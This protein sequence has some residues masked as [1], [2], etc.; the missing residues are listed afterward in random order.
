M[1]GALLGL[2]L[3]W[4]RF[5]RR[6]VL[7]LTAG[8]SLTV[9]PWQIARTISDHPLA[10]DRVSLVSERLGFAF[11][12]LAL[13]QPVEDALFFVTLMTILFW[14][15]GLYSGYVFMRY[16]GILSAV[17]PVTIPVLV[18]QYYD[19]GSQAR[20]WLTGFYFFLCLLL[21]G[22]LNYVQNKERW[23]KQ[24]VFLIPEIG[25]DLNSTTLAAVTVVMV[26]AWSMPS[27]RA[28]WK[29]AI[30]WWRKT[31]DSFENT[32]ERLGDALAAVQGAPPGGNNVLYGST[33]PLGQR[34]YQ[35]DQV[36]LVVQPQPLE[37]PP[38]RLYWRM[39][40]YDTYNNAAWSHSNDIVD[41]YLPGTAD[42]RTPDTATRFPGEFIFTN[43]ADGQ[44][45]I[46]T[47]PQPVWVSRDALISYTRLPDNL[48]DVDRLRADPPLRRDEA[49][50]ARSALVAP[51]VADL[52]QAGT[53][54][55]KWVTD[56]YLQLPANL[57]QSIRHLG[58]ELTRGLETP[59]DKAAAITRYLR[60]EITYSDEIPA[61][62]SG[63]DRLEWF[64]L[65]W[66]QGYCNYAASAEVVM[67]R[68]AGVPARM[69]AGFAQ[70]KRDENGFY[71]VR[72]RDAHAWPEVYFPGI[73][74]VE[75]EPTLNQNPLIRPAG[76]DATPPNE[77][78]MLLN[79]KDLFFD[80]QLAPPSLEEEPLPPQT[81]QTAGENV[82]RQMLLW[83]IIIL[84]ASAAGFG[85]WRFNRSQPLIPRALR[86]VIQIYER[87][88]WSAPAWMMSWIRWSESPPITRT[89]NSINAS[90]RWLGNPAPIHFTPAERA[91]ALVQLLPQAE[92]AITALLH[93]QQA[94]LYTPHPGDPK[95]AR[96]AS[97]SIR[98]AALL[99]RLQRL[100][101]LLER[102]SYPREY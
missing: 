28:E 31:A 65:S 84:A 70:G 40:S 46:I 60:S 37:H 91:A 52:R 32:R 9:I 69:V 66:K 99:A 39:R 19:G 100:S 6:G 90:L 53:D 38:P 20:L 10:Y 29:S 98:I 82:V 102:R 61:P 3:G 81:P 80:D 48:M 63:R 67:L 58:L 34:T 7:L 92:E 101:A 41:E 64:L 13:R 36:L 27:S 22:R 75:F 24:N 25:F 56:R 17:V 93:E 94:T 5:K 14:C 87:N 76:V 8:Y 45:T 15:L 16:G 11:N 73:G 12:Q 85:V 88:N 78:D 89:F 33:L 83:G 96:H 77:D 51:T 2:A 71:V 59:Y 79:R 21:L 62:P 97:L 68:A 23:R 44:S 54:Y 43:K 74:W 42:I 49:Y 55:P 57:P 18:I 72:Q 4:S 35:G 50:A 95:R 26:I 30:Q 47:G 1:F 86:F